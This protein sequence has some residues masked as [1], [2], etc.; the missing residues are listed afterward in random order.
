MKPETPTEL[1]GTPEVSDAEPHASVSLLDHA[2]VM[3]RSLP[4]SA[5]P[6][7]GKGAELRILAGRDSVSRL[8]Y[9]RRTQHNW[10]LTHQFIITCLLAK[11]SHIIE[12]V[13]VSSRCT[14]NYSFFSSNIPSVFLKVNLR[15]DADGHRPRLRFS[16]PG[17]SFC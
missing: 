11:L 14:A 1:R 13:V 4:L 8:L 10:S 17:Q 7:A 9:P 3:L 12:N 6:W 15:A 16:L 5:V 2:S